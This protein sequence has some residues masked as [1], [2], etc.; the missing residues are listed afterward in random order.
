MT[1]IKDLQQQLVTVMKEAES[2]RQAYDGEVDD[3]SAEEE[4]R[5]NQL[6]DEGDDIA[7]KIQRLEREQK[8][9]AYLNDPITP[10]KYAT[11]GGGGGERKIGRDGRERDDDDV[12]AIAHRKAFKKF[13]RGGLRSL[14][15]TEEKALQADNP[16]GG[17]FLVAPEQFVRDLLAN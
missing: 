1:D 13:L 15:P 10:M 8:L 2:I 9:Q 4:S 11:S 14:T 3:M 5:W 17:G 6:L 12:S 16:V 7:S